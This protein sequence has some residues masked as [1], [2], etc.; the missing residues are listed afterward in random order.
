VLG[1]PLE[2]RMEPLLIWADLNK[3]EEGQPD[4]AM[5]VYSDKPV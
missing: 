3:T 2:E 1:R 5:R 4:Q